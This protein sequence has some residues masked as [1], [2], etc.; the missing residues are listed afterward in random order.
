MT[1]D[2]RELLHIVLDGSPVTVALALTLLDRKCK[3]KLSRL[4]KEFME[5]SKVKS[6]VLR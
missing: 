1:T 2:K 5:Y 4:L 6:R 3:G